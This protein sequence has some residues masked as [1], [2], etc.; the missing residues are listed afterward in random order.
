MAHR[1]S[2]SRTEGFRAE[3]T[4]EP[5]GM[6]RRVKL[7]L[8]VLAVLALLFVAILQVGGSDGPGG[9]TSPGG[10]VPPPGAHK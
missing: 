1:L 2:R 7:A 6:R 10:H 3:P 4:G 9:G 5:G 8:V